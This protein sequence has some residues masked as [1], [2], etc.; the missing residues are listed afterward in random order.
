MCSE[1]SRT[2]LTPQ[3][4]LEISYKR[5]YTVVL[6]LRLPFRVGEV[7]CILL[8]SGRVRRVS[9]VRRSKLKAEPQPRRGKTHTSHEQ[10]ITASE[11][12]MKTVKKTSTRSLS[13]RSSKQAVISVDERSLTSFPDP[14]ASPKDGGQSTKS[15]LDGLLDASN[16]DLFNENEEHDIMDPQSLSAAPE[17]ALNAVV[18]ANGAANLVRRLAQALAER[19]AHVTALR[20]LA[21]EYHAPQSEIFDTLSR[22]SRSTSRRQDLAAAVSE[23]TTSMGNESSK[24]AYRPKQP[25]SSVMSLF[26]GHKRSQDV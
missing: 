2:F 21:E 7:V 8:A 14:P 4:A 20:R 22:S 16:E 12:S 10:A 18:E 25:R 23:T 1:L 5:L 9:T 6:I 15:L 24:P 11:S 26:G 19:D 17:S 3:S 13:R